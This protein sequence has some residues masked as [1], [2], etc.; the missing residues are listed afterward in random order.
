[1]AFIDLTLAFDTVPRPTLWKIISKVGWPD[2]L[3][4]IVRI[5]HDGMKAS[6][7]VDGD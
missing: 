1:M 5:L 6:V 4:N 2:K 3:I 7:H